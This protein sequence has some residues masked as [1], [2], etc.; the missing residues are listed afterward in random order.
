MGHPATGALEGPMVRGLPVDHQGMEQKGLRTGHFVALAGALVAFASLWRPWYTIEI[1]QQLRDLMSGSGALG[2]DPGLLGQMARGL[3]TALPSSISASGWRELEG[4][5][6]T[7]AVGA[8]AVVA[9]V[10][11]AAGALGGAVRVDASACGKLVAAIGAGLGVLAIVHVVHKPGAGAPGGVRD[12]IKVADGVWIAL[13]GAVAIVV[14]GLWA[15]ADTGTVSRATATAPSPAPTAFP[16]LT[17][18]LPPVFAEAPG[19]AAS[20]VPPPF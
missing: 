20:S 12:L 19:A 10:L 14:G 1:P 6:V 5:D 9:L 2:Q 7:V 4:A 15:A 13:G 3:A 16:P 8:V 11:G 17:P 18:D